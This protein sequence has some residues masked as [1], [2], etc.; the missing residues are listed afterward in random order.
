MSYGFIA[1]NSQGQTVINDSQPL[2]VQKRS[3]N[4]P[5]FG[6][7][8]IGVNKFNTSS[9]AN[10]VVSSGEILMLSCNVGS[11]ITFNLPVG[12][13]PNFIGEFCSNQTSLSYKVFGPRTDLPNPTGYN[14]AVFNTSGQCMWDAQ[15]T[16]VRINNGGR[17][18]G[19]TTA[20]RTY[21]SATVS[22]SNSA[23]CTAGSAVLA[24]TGSSST[25]GYYQMSAFRSNTTSWIFRQQRVTFEN[26]GGLVGNFFFVSDFSY[27]LGVS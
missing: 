11:W 19:S 24:F 10:A 26:G 7:T 4:L 9:S 6:T 2:Y 1:T 3:G 16:A 13:D 12:N 15:S 18:P 22:G 8:N 27:L 21:S 14:M 5:S 20:N 25:S 17:I 23:Y